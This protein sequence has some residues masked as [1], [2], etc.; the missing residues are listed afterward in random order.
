MCIARDGFVV[1]QLEKKK[2]CVCLRVGLCA[3]FGYR[4]SQEWY[5][6]DRLGLFI[7]YCLNVCVYA[8]ETYLRETCRYKL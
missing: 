8:K 3:S 7:S 1:H 5:M 2:W 4:S 6:L